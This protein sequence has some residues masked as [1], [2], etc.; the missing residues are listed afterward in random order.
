MLNEWAY[1]RPYLNNDA[2]LDALPSWL[3]HY[4][5]NRAH[6]ALDGQT[7]MAILVSNVSGNHI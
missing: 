7:P 1:A 3:D 4:N 2:R 6:T 5:R